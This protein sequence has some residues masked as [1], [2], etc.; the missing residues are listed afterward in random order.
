MNRVCCQIWFVFGNNGRTTGFGSAKPAFLF[1]L[2]NRVETILRPNLGVSVA[3]RM[4]HPERYAVKFGQCAETL[5]LA[6]LLADAAAL[7]LGQCPNRRATDSLSVS[8]C[9]PDS[10]S[11]PFPYQ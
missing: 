10:R 2:L 3:G 11:D 4:R 8:S 9:F 7:I 1:S 6:V 5:A